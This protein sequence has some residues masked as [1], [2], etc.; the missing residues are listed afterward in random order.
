M[1]MRAEIFPKKLIKKK[2]I[3]AY[4]LIING[5]KFLLVQ[6]A[7]GK[8]RGLW[9]LPGGGVKKGELPRQAA[10]RE[11]EE[12][13]GYNI[14]II[15]KVG[16]YNDKEKMSIRNVFSARVI[17]GELK[18]RKIELMDAQW[19][20]LEEVQEIKHKLR[21]EWVWEAINTRH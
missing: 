1:N 4:A 9:G 2:R 13:V 8:I 6:E 17:G 12:E 21:G 5:D 16:T 11:A 7:V 18:T 3:T 10:E 20:A 14:E 19:F 15:G